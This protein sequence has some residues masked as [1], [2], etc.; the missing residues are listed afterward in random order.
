M[1]FFKCFDLPEKKPGESMNTADRL[2]LIKLIVITGFFTAS[3]GLVGNM[4]LI[5]YAIKRIDKS[6]QAM[7]EWSKKANLATE[8][9]DDLYKVE[10]QKEAYKSQGIGAEE[11]KVKLNKKELK[12]EKQN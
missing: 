12:N 5:E 9:L 3:L 6:A 4:L 11:T 1:G 8:L 2:Y 7:K 10:K